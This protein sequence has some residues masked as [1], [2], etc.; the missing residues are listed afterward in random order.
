M[1]AEAMLAAL[2]APIAP[3]AACRMA[4]TAAI[5]R[6]LA[7]PVVARA[8]V[9]A[10]AV[11]MREG[12]AVAA[13]ETLG[14]SAFSPLP[15]PALPPRLGPGDVVPAGL[16]A[17]LDVFD[18]DEAG[19]FPQVLQPATPGDGLRLPGAEIA[20]GAAIRAAGERLGARDLPALAALAVD[21]VMVRIPRLALRHS[22]AAIGGLVAAWARAEG[23]DCGMW[24]AGVAADLLLLEGPPPASA[25]LGLG[26]R[27][28]MMAGI[29]LVEG[30][31]AVLLPRLAQ[32]ALAAWVLLGL[33]A[34]RRLA[35]AVAPAA[36]RVR[37]ARKVAS[38]V[39]LAEL[40]LLAIDAEGVATPLS[41]GG[42]PL[43]A[44]AQADGL[45]VVPAGAEGYD[46]GAMI[47]ALPLP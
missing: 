21:S 5:G 44:L 39:G 36:R 46:A 12:W 33:P 20:A 19:P 17:L 25:V 29:A 9:P 31:P 13:A 32:D 14:A 43:A 18:L 45:L 41:V 6:V 35:G 7:E 2:L 26:A 42:L 22:D 30:V 4:A 11:A 34:L 1:P 16:D 23:A 15:L 40:V 10:Q 37:L 28:G 24:E 3:V 27:P 47:D 38:G 8:G